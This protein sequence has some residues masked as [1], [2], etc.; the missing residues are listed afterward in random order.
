MSPRALVTCGVPQGS[1][2]GPLLFSLYIN[3]LPLVNQMVK[4]NL[5][6]DD[7]AITASANS[8]DELV[9]VLNDVLSQVSEWFCYN[10][11]SLN[12]KKTQ[13]MVFGTR[14]MLS[15]Q[16][17]IEI[18]F[19]EHVL[20]PVNSVKYLGIT[21]DSHLTFHEHVASICNRTVGKIKLLGRI[22]G[23]IPQQTNLMLYKTLI[24]PIF[25]YCDFVWDCVNQQDSQTLQKLQNMALKN[26][27]QV[28]RL[29]PTDYVHQTLNMPY[30]H[31]RRKQHTASMMY[32]VQNQL[33]PTGLQGMFEHVQNTSGRVT[34]QSESNNFHIPRRRLE[35]GKRCFSHRGPVVWQYTPEILKSAPS[36]KAFCTGIRELWRVDG[37]LGI[38]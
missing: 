24:L 8:R 28:D 34:R 29:T 7:T 30:L 13:F 20:K 33:V 4:W 19:E 3:D 22:S 31:I 37:D 14:Q 23:F 27:L 25:D 21:L 1:I 11:L 9:V 5:Y 15:R 38:T 10:R 18:V 2:L 26:V 12:V 6:A 16:E 17:N 32:K 36:Y 35:L